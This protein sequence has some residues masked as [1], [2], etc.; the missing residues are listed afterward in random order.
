MTTLH[1]RNKRTIAL[2]A[3]LRKKYMAINPCHR[4]KALEVLFITLCRRL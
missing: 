1:I 2:P 3:S 4:V